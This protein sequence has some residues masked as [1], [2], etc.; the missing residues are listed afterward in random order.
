MPLGRRFQKGVSGNPAGVP[1]DV[2]QA[3]VAIRQALA[4]HADEIDAAL[5]SLVREGNVTAVVYAHR[6]LHGDPEVS[7]GVHTDGAF[8]LELKE[9]MRKTTAQLVASVT[10]VIKIDGGQR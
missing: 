1:A 2:A 5:L 4:S 8:E 9:A 3:R 10:E 7:V 6:A